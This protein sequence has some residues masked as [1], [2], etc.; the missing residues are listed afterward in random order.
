MVS[1]RTPPGHTAW[2]S[3]L[4]GA[5]PSLHDVHQQLVGI[6]AEAARLQKVAYF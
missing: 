5:A 3:E 2:V 6:V 1:D 4:R